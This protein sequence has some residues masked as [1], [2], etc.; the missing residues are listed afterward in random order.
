MAYS[1]AEISG[2]L[3]KDGEPLNIG[4]GGAKP[5]VGAIMSEQEF[6]EQI[7]RRI[8]D[9]EEWLSAVLNEMLVDLPPV[10]VTYEEFGIPPIDES[11]VVEGSITEPN[12]RMI[13][14]RKEA[15]E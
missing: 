8:G 4:C 11:K 15:H 7:K 13:A 6:S 3:A 12:T 14:E 10:Y 9:V 1:I 5:G 2:T